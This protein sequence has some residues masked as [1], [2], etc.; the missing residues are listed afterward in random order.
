MD[1]YINSALKVTSMKSNIQETSPYTGNGCVDTSL[2]R[3]FLF[4]VLEFKVNLTEQLF[5]EY[6]DNLEKGII[7]LNIFRRNGSEWGIRKLIEKCCTTTS[8]FDYEQDLLLKIPSLPKARE[9]SI[10]PDWIQNLLRTEVDMLQSLFLPCY[11]TYR[12]KT[13]VGGE[14]LPLLMTLRVQIF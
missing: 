13:S 5:A 3:W 12:I 1:S 7:S 11:E 6:C 14:L 8:V 9:L 10:I 2:N 4:F